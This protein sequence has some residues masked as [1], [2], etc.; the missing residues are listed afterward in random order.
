MPLQ[1]EAR[2]LDN[3]ETQ[4]GEGVVD[5]M[6]WVDADSVDTEGAYNHGEDKTGGNT[7]QPEEAW[8]HKGNVVEAP[9]QR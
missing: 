2:N 4:E 8:L 9:V 6:N 5:R 3:V 1:Q 7:V